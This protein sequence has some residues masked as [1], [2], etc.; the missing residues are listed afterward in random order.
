MYFVVHRYHQVDQIAPHKH[1]YLASSA[2]GESIVVKLMFVDY[3]C[4]WALHQEMAQAGITPK[5]VAPPSTYGGVQAVRMEHLSRAEGWIPLQE[6]DGDWDAAS[7]LCLTA[8]GCM[9]QC[10]SS[11]AVHGDLRAPNVMIR[12]GP[13]YLYNLVTISAK[14]LLS[15]Y[16]C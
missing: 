3:P 14:E 8:L 11:H 4:P 2:E 10:L 1:V 12:C 15:K 9:Q 5:L 13:S 6:F 7:D 16:I